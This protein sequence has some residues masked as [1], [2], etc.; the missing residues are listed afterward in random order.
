MNQ[1][2][3]AIEFEIAQIKYEI[4]K[5]KLDLDEI[6]NEI[7]LMKIMTNEIEKRISKIEKS[8]WLSD[9]DDK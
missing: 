1:S 3:D 5:N 6:R 9:D 7:E 4:I 8:Y 2:I